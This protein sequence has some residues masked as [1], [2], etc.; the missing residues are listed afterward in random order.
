MNPSAEQILNV[1]DV[2]RRLQLFTAAREWDQFHS[3]K[4]LVMA[5]T[6]EAGE[7]VEVFL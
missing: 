6:G 4:N 2:Q 7:L 1:T 5:L 3:P